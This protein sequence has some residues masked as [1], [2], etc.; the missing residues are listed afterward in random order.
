M[1]WLTQPV[2]G[3]IEVEITFDCNLKCRHCNRFCNSEEDYN[4]S[5]NNSNMNMEHINHLCFEIMRFPKL[6][7]DTIRIIGGEPLVS[8]KL[9]EAIKVFKSL[10]TEGYIRNII[11]VTNGTIKA[12]DEIKPFI[13]LLPEELNSRYKSKGQLTNREVYQVKNTKHRNISVVPA[14]FD[15]HGK[16]CDRVLLCG[17]NYSIYGFSL[18]APC[19]TPLILFPQNHKHFLYEIPEYFGDFIFND[20]EKDVC[21]KC[22]F[23]DIVPGTSIIRNND[24]FIGET[25]QRQIEQNLIA[26]EE[27]DTS[28]I[29]DYQKSI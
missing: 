26:Y 5:R 28:W 24:S 9:N 18:C 6:R 7:F 23:C 20:F 21:S 29:H 4:L 11:I 22:S 12:S 15:L 2:G 17:I 25:W 16:L 19:L 8:S 10:I 3:T 1:K 13:K 27:P 14:D